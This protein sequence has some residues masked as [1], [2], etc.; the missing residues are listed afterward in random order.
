LKELDDL[1]ARFEGWEAFKDELEAAIGGGVLDFDEEIRPQLDNPLAAAIGGDGH[2]IAALRLRDPVALRRAVEERVAEGEAKRLP[3]YKGAYLWRDRGSRASEPRASAIAEGY[4]VVADA[5]QALKDAIDARAESDN[6]ASDESLVS[7]LEALGD[8]ALARVVGDGRRLLEAGDPGAAAD[9]ARRIP[10]IAALGK[11][12]AVARVGEE[13]V[14]IAFRLRTDRRRLSRDELPLPPGTEAPRLHDLE[15]AAALGVL[16]PDRLVRFIERVVEVLEPEQFA[17]YGA[18]IDQLRS[19]FG[20]DLHRDLLRKITNLSVALAAGTAASFQARL[21]RGAGPEVARALARARPYVEEVL[22]DLVPGVTVAA[23]GQG[24]RR[25]YVVRQGPLPIARYGVRGDALVGSVGFADL[26]E[27][28][29]G[30]KVRGTAG[31]LVVKADPGRLAALVPS[32]GIFG[33]GI[34][35]G[36]LDLL[37]Q[38]GELTLSVQAETGYLSGRA[39]LDAE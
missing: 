11:L 35:R 16:E 2:R 12:T 1:G 15:A 38:L 14:R 26:P 32:D 33:D 10:W 4:L 34:L 21:E 8:D 29:G 6:V 17:P 23:Q 25:L 5:E 30:R 9:A 39:R 28:A 27:P 19:T 7:E 31:A 37:S 36:T 24:R 18:A 20:V 3:D 22:R 13:H